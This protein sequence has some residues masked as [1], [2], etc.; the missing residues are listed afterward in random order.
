MN[1]N[2]NF[3][4]YGY[5]DMN[6]LGNLFMSGNNQNNNQ[7]NINS[8]M[9]QNKN[10][11]EPYEAFIRGNLYNNLYQQYKNYRP[12][13]LVP[14]N[15]QAELLLNIDQL[16]FAAHELNLYLDIFPDNQMMIKLFNQYTEMANNAIKKYEE[17]YGPLTTGSQSNLNTFSWQAYSWPWEMEEM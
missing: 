1:N 15:E 9:N 14:N 8:N 17:K 12:A 7:G 4:G 2:M 5:P 13:R 3:D 10:L 11:L 16:T 6:L